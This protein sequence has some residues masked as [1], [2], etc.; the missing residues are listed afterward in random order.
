MIS[1]K[2]VQ[3]TCKKTKK[4]TTFTKLIKKHVKKQK[5]T[6]LSQKPIKKHVKKQKKTKKTMFSESMRLEQKI[7]P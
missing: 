5:K 4:T 3:K 6:W 2:P 7:L 1:A